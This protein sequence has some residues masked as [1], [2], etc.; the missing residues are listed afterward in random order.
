MSMAVDIKEC[1]ECEMAESQAVSPA[2]EIII[3]DFL[4]DH[5]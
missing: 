1:S 4:I 5:K 3:L 2:Y